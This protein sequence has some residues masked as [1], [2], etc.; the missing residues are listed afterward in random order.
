MGCF[1]TVMLSCPVCGKQYSAQSKS[2]PCEMGFYISP[3]IAPKE[4]MTDI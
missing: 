3:L 1:E 4:V 2:G